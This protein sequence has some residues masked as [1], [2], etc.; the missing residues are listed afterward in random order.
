MTDVNVGVGIDDNGSLGKYLAE[1]KRLDAEIAK[2]LNKSGKVSEGFEAQFKADSRKMKQL[3]EAV[4]SYARTQFDQKKLVPGTKEYNAEYLRYSNFIK[5]I[6]Q[7]DNDNERRRLESI[8][9]I[10]AAEKRRRDAKIREDETQKRR[11][12]QHQKELDN[13]TKEQA[14]SQRNLQLQQIK[15]R[16]DLERLDP[17]QVRQL[18]GQARYMAK[19]QNDRGLPAKGFENQ[20]ALLTGYL[21]DLAKPGI[22]RRQDSINSLLSNPQQLQKFIK[23]ATPTM[24]QEFQRSSRRFSRQAFDS[25]DSFRGN[26]LA[27]LAGQFKT[28][29]AEMAPTFKSLQKVT[30]DILNPNGQMLKNVSSENLKQAQAQAAAIQRQMRKAY[31]S[32]KPEE[33]KR[34]EK[35]LNQ[36]NS[37]ITQ[38]SQA[39]S[40]QR[41]NELSPLLK[42]GGN[43]EQQFNTLVAGK[44]E[45][46]LYALRKTANT[47]FKR[48][49]DQNN[50]YEAQGWKNIADQLGKHLK[51]QKDALKVNKSSST[52]PNDVIARQAQIDR[53]RINEFAQSRYDGRALA[54]D[55]AILQ[56]MDAVD[57]D[58]LKKQG[59]QRLKAQQFR[60]D[61]ATEK[62]RAEEE[63]ILRVLKEQLA[64]IEKQASIRKTIDTNN[65]KKANPEL[66]A[67]RMAEQAQNAAQRNSPEANRARVAQNIQQS[68][69]RREMDGGAEMFRNQMMLLRNYAVMG[70]GVGGVASTGSFVVGLDKSFKQLQ[71]I[72]ALTTNDMSKLKGE[73]IAVS[74]LTKFDALEV[75]DTSIILGQAG[76]NKEQ[77]VRS[78]EG[79]TLF[80]TAVGTDLKSAVDL[81][82]SALGIYNIE[83]SRMPEVVDK[84]TISIN[85]SKLNMDKLSLGMQYAGNIAEQSN[86]S[87]EETVSALAAMANSGIKSGSTLGTGLRQILITLQKPSDAFKKKMRELGI[88][89]DQLD[90]KTHSLTD[91]M[92]TLSRAGF[93]VVDAM[94]TM[95]VRAAAAFGAYANNLDT[96]RNITKQMQQGGAATSANVVQMEALSN[97]WARFSSVAKSIFYDAL[98][99]MVVMLSKLLKNTTDWLSEL[100]ASGDMIQYI[101]AGLT[102]LVAL[103][104]ALGLF[105]LGI[106]LF[107]GAK[108]V[109]GAGATAG[110][111]AG[112]GGLAAATTTAT[113]AATAATVT[114]IV[115]TILGGPWI[116]GIAAAGAIGSGLY[117]KFSEKSRLNDPLDKAK[118]NMNNIEARI[119]RNN[120]GVDDITKSIS[121]AFY[122]K[123]VFDDS[124]EGVERLSNFVAE[125]NSKLRSV[126]FNMDPTTASFDGLIAKLQET[127]GKLLEFND[128]ELIKQASAGLDIAKAEADKLK[129]GKTFNPF[130]G[131]RNSKDEL[132][133][134]LNFAGVNTSN[135]KDA[136][137]RMRKLQSLQE[138]SPELA[139][140]FSGTGRVSEGN[141]QASQ[142]EKLVAEIKNLDPKNNSSADYESFINRLSP[143]L[144]ELGSAKGKDL[145]EIATRNGITEREL[146]KLIQDLENEVLT[147][148]QSLQSI[149]TSLKPSE[150]MET[151]A[152]IN[153]LTAEMKARFEIPVNTL[154][155]DLTTQGQ[156]LVNSQKAITDP[157]GA[158]RDYQAFEEKARAQ[159]RVMAQEMEAAIKAQIAD[160][161]L[162]TER[163]NYSQLVNNLPLFT[164][165]NGFEASVTRDVGELSGPALR[166]AQSRNRTAQSANSENIK[167]LED[168]LKD[169]NNAD[170]I[171]SL[172]LRLIALER[173]QYE[174]DKE[175]AILSA[176]GDLE[177]RNQ[178]LENLESEFEAKLSQIRSQE[179]RALVRTYTAD[180]IRQN[181]LTDTTTSRAL[182]Q[183]AVRQITSVN[184]QNRQE[185]NLAYTKAQESIRTLRE[186]ERLAKAK[187]SDA[188][189][190]ANTPEGLKNAEELE[191]L[192]AEAA[193]KLLGAQVNALRDL[194]T[195]KTQR[196]DGLVSLSEQ[197]ASP[198]V[199]ATLARLITTLEQEISKTAGDI[200]RLDERPELVDF[201]A[202]ANIDY[203]QYR[204]DNLLNSDAR[205]A[206]RAEAEI[207][208][209]EN[210]RSKS[211]E[212]ELLRQRQTDA[213]RLKTQAEDLKRVA[214][215]SLQAARDSAMPDNQQLFALNTAAQA[216]ER[217]NLAMLEYLKAQKEALDLDIQAKRLRL[218]N[219]E[220]TL[221]L[222]GLDNLSKK[223]LEGVVNELK[224]Q[225]AQ[226]ERD[227]EGLNR[228][229]SQNTQDG[230]KQTN[231]IKGNTEQLRLAGRRYMDEN[232]RR[233]GAIIRGEQYQTDAQVARGA[234]E[235][236]NPETL[237]GGFGQQVKN[238]MDSVFTE[239]LKAYEGMDALTETMLGFTDI[240]AGA[241]DQAGSFFSQFASGSLSAGDAFRG[242]GMTVIQSLT[243]M[244]AKIAMNAIMQQVI[245]FAA[246]AFGPSI[247]P[248]AGG[249][250]LNSGFQTAWN[251]GPVQAPR[252]MYSGGYVNTGMRSRDSTLINAAKGEFVLRQAAVDA[253]GLEGA[254]TLNRLDK[255][256]VKSLESVKPPE[257]K[258]KAEGDKTVNVWI[259]SE[260][261]AQQP[262]MDPNSILVVVDKALMRNSSTKKLVKRISLGDL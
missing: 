18:A 153:K 202:N 194:G 232:R 94:Q 142:Y 46:G 127:R 184:T 79:I 193:K 131:E 198:E 111:A 8:K 200:N 14:R 107:A 3:Q 126:G 72:L 70:A 62:T 169:A 222:P 61:T 197:E 214:D 137:I 83:A 231:E 243:D 208:K 158:Y 23:E 211:E 154:V 68:Q 226:G 29:L 115:R 129:G 254:H 182:S 55:P 113:T 213:E 175:L 152:A 22:A 220:R 38:V 24:L 143:L 20:L 155:A 177:T 256:T 12:K 40:L 30:N 212:Q 238:G 58:G 21:R 91:V 165:L 149:A 180:D 206:A 43:F 73:L 261:E 192:A 112:V 133:Q 66:Q 251:G 75:V 171:E 85:K 98:E 93:T 252:R 125:L 122:K 259:V 118:F 170:Q 5:S 141:F 130:G 80:A 82:T 167:A 185:E 236:T 52:D 172:T 196:L 34:Y 223:A 77:I 117:T 123:N 189:R 173:E 163:D 81:A 203:R 157:L 2:L 101:V 166:S 209:S 199:K 186:E 218:E 67:N 116:W 227:L 146:N 105:N 183:A 219:A 217:A 138:L 174:R 27:Q 244:A 33:G 237:A 15:S 187:A 108:G 215:E 168:E 159:L 221:A 148:I 204:F 109:L 246:S 224:P 104:G 31:Q 60:A 132:R 71:S 4:K 262:S 195:A 250:N 50:Q 7:L 241:G 216:M 144:S 248:N 59:Q 178:A 119:T 87:F 51:E 150:T 124:A 120:M 207:L 121:Q 162:L 1:I 37:K 181:G 92:T 106:R 65:A 128:I 135:Y 102:T 76:L 41:K 161:E 35:A 25:G 28:A 39:A 230:I 134:R 89:M 188:K 36:L 90:L 54:K 229:I 74:E 63:R 176:K 257:T 140:I 156:A 45:A 84:L 233:M 190:Y 96:A 19:F 160:S 86:V 78:I 240:L 100:K 53:A 17:S 88:G 136:S 151:D 42:S 26:N 99:P 245:M 64:V 260:E 242:F 97:Q 235:M 57:L 16:K 255:N 239:S 253:I 201:R 228:Q 9:K 147:K 249:P 49:A 56:R 205:R 10:E 139:G 110:A 69:I 210:A 179:Q 191:L 145:N 11:H 48:L 164:S 47:E 114:T 258:E 95:E 6:G 247:G 225:I 32:D 234:G 13:Q 44:N 103:K